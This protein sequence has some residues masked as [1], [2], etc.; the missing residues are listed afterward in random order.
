MIHWLF[1][2]ER[3]VYA[4]RLD[5]TYRPLP[6]GAEVTP[7]ASGWRWKETGMLVQS[8]RENG[9]RYTA[10][11][12]CSAAAIVASIASGVC[13]VLVTPASNCKGAS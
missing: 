7:M 2:G 3:R 1:L 8:L 4:E 12:A 10:W 9:H 5:E 6:V 13:V 11:K